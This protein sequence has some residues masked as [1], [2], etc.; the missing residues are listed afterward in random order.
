VTLSTTLP[1]TNTLHHGVSSDDFH[2]IVNNYDVVNSDVPM[3]SLFLHDFWGNAMRL[4]LPSWLAVSGET[5]RWTHNSYRP[6]VVFTFRLN[7]WMAG[8]IS[9]FRAF[10]VTNVAVHA[11]ACL[12]ALKLLQLIMGK[13]QRLHAT[14]AAVIFAVHPIHTEVVANATSRAETMCGTVMVAALAAYW[15]LCG[16]RRVSSSSG[17]SSVDDSSVAASVAA[18]PKPR[19]P[20]RRGFALFCVL[21]VV[22]VLCKETA[23]VVPMMA[24]AVDV[25]RAVCCGQSTVRD[26]AS[27]HGKRR[28]A[29]SL[30]RRIVVGLAHV[31][32][33]RVAGLLAFQVLLLY[34]RVT[35]LSSG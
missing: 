3:L 35:L 13:P 10:H 24:V 22:A 16:Q 20:W 21:T 28:V 7:R 17:D 18:A 2:A 4:N 32:W 25:L 33:G 5:P 6:L 30:Q 23:L 31:H 8:G 1:Y 14:L 9:D 27:D 11:V 34:C 19:V 15:Q 12:A 29:S 26:G